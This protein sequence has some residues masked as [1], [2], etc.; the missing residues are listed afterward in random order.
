MK[1]DPTL[2]ILEDWA[3]EMGDLLAG[4]TDETKNPAIC[5][6]YCGI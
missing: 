5:V 1:S 6:E 3:R 4:K 2:P